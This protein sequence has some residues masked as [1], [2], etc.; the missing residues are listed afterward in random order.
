M[1][2][3]IL[4][5]VIK[6]VKISWFLIQHYTVEEYDCNCRRYWSLETKNRAADNTAASSTAGPYPPTRNNNYS[7]LMP[8]ARKSFETRLVEQIQSV[9]MQLHNT[10]FFY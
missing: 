10:C 3:Q 6:N 9:E 2:Y 5:K 1:A 8:G 4:H 7:F